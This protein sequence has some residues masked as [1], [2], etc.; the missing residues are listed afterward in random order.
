MKKTLDSASA[1]GE[2]TP[3]NQRENGRR[4]MASWLITAI[5]AILCVMMAFT[6]I[7]CT[8]DTVNDSST[9]TNTTEST[10]KDIN[11]Y[12]GYWHISA[13]PDRELEI[14]DISADGKTIEFSLRFYYVSGC[15]ENLTATLEGDVA[16]FTSDDGNLVGHLKLDA[17]RIAMAIKKSDREN[18]PVGILVFNGQHETNYGY[19]ENYS[20]NN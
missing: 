17:G 15:D 5:V 10:Y 8:D 11:D 13:S 20:D 1:I 12:K 7:A 4:N 18:L 6:G 14:T 9:N 2:F 16:E 19:D 3:V